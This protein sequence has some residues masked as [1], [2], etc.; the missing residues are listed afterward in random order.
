M[1]AGEHDEPSVGRE[2]KRSAVIQALPADV[3][4]PD[5]AG[6]VTRGRATR[7]SGATITAWM[8]SVSTLNT[9][10]LTES[11]PMPKSKL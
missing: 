1:N 5:A 3:D 8:I 6:D 2:G 11:C 9:E 7:C 10:K 4:A